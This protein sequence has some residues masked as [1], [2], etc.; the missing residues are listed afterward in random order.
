MK[1]RNSLFDTARLT[2][3]MSALD[4]RESKA[5]SLNGWKGEDQPG[6]ILAREE[7]GDVAKG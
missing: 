3:W 5:G 4:V 2:Y 1:S 6:E 7:V